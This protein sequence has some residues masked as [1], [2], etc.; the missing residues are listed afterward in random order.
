MTDSNLFAIEQYG[1]RSGQSTELAT[2][3]LIDYLTMQINIR[4]ILI[5]I[6]IDLSKAFDTLITLYYWQNF[7]IMESVELHISW[8]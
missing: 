7:V 4:E 1:F 8:C 6:H 3:H 2:L 5:N